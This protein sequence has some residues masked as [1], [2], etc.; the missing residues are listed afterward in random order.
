M[1]IITY[2]TKH[3]DVSYHPMKEAI[4]DKERPD[5]AKRLKYSKDVL[6]AL[7]DKKRAQ[8]LEKADLEMNLQ[9][10]DD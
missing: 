9:D 6:L 1:D 5:I 2:V 8:A 4:I 10:Q 7:I 3:G